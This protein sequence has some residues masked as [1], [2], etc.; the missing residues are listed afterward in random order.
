MEFFDY[1]ITP[2]VETLFPY[3]FY[4]QCVYFTV[5]DLKVGKRWISVFYV[6]FLTLFGSSLVSIIIFDESP[7]W[8]KDSEYIITFLMVYIPL[9]L[10]SNFVRKFLQSI[11]IQTVI[12]F[13]MNLSI[14]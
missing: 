5:Y 7:G 6:F 8:I 13:G 4:F 3:L 14:R 10:F 2:Y 12:S 1:Y 11:F 9:I